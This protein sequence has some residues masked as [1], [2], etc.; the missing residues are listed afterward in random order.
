MMATIRTADGVSL[1]VE[2]QGS[3]T[4]LVFVHEFGGTMRSFDPQLAA[5]RGRFRCI[6]FNARGYPPSDVPP[7]VESYSQDIAA[8]D[9]GAVLDGLGITEKAHLVGVSMGAASVVQFALRHPARVRSITPVSIGT[10][11]D[12]RPEE[13]QA[14]MEETARLIDVEGMALR[15]AAMADA[16]NRRK[17]KDK[18]RP[19][20]D[21]FLAD[22]GALSP[23]GA[24]NT[25]RGVQK[26][27]PPLYA[28]ETAIR[29]LQVPA[30]VVV[31]ED[32]AGCR[33]PSEFLAHTLPNATLLVV[34]DTGHG[35]N[36]EEPALFNAK[37]L[38]FLEAH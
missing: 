25:M 31:G 32:D 4:P 27:R 14:A 23:L 19:L 22:I 18:N 1:A 8:S 10:G 7:S 38:A 20:Y 6:T 21:A 24:A 37:L 2:E 28:H 30:L 17:L 11:S 26:R 34:P 5:F 29:T 36:L 12:A 15:A 13:H 16:P 33:K 3:G 35:V 9:I